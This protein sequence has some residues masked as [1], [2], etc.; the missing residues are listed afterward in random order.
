MRLHIG[1]AVPYGQGSAGI[2]GF[3][4]NPF[5]STPQVQ[6][7]TAML[8]ANSIPPPTR[9]QQHYSVAPDMGGN[10]AKCPIRSFEGQRPKSLLLAHRTG[11][12]HAATRRV[13]LKQILVAAH[14]SALVGTADHTPEATL[15]RSHGDCAAG[16]EARIINYA[17]FYAILYQTI[18]SASAKTT[19][20]V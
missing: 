17:R 3:L 19:T 18:H 10:P 20:P 15:S 16:S 1:R 11:G 8:K 9:S 6:T 4:H 7:A 12:A 5:L 13:C 14:V 2:T